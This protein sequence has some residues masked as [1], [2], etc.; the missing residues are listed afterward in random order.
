ML[1]CGMTQKDISDLHVGEVD[2]AEGRIIR[3]RSK[4]ADFDSVPEVNYLLWPET[5]RLLGQERAADS[6]DCVLLNSAGA[7]LWFESLDERGKYQKND[8]IKNAFDRL[9]KK[10]GINKPLKSLKKTS[11]TMLRNE[12]RFQGTYAHFLGHAP[13]SIA[14]KH[15]TQPSQELLDQAI[16]WLG[17][18]FGVVQPS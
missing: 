15:Y 17:I 3:K 12:S 16:Q 18:E 4:T 9:R 2:W 7:R 10:V 1:N 11:A 13:Q 6:Q 8:N 14:D 5:L